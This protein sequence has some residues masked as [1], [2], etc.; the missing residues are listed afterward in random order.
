MYQSSSRSL[1]LKGWNPADW[2]SVAVALDGLGNPSAL[3]THLD[4]FS[5]EVEGSKQNDELRSFRFYMVG[6]VHQ[7]R[8]EYDLALAAYMRASASAGSFEKRAL[9]MLQTGMINTFLGERREAVS[10]LKVALR[11]A[12]QQRSKPDLLSAAHAADFLAGLFSKSNLAIAHRYLKQARRHAAEIGNKHRLDW[13]LFTEGEITLREGDVGAG[14]GLMREALNS[15]ELTGNRSS[16]HHCCARLGAFLFDFDMLAEA[17]AIL[18]RGVELGETF[19]Y[20]RSRTRILKLRAD[21]L[22][23]LGEL[24]PRS[25]QQILD[26]AA[27]LERRARGTWSLMQLRRRIFSESDITEF[28]RTLDPELFESLCFRILTESG[29]TCRRT[30]ES[31]PYIDIVASRDAGMSEQAK[32]AVSCKR[33]NTKKVGTAAIPNSDKIESLGCSGLMIMTSSRISVH[34]EA[35]LEHL[36]SRR[37]WCKVWDRVAL[38]EFLADHDWL[39]A[40]LGFA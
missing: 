18:E 36:K 40:E 23:R 14:L 11:N 33:W 29:F 34:A 31:A 2:A 27:I 37:I 1:K 17:R 9:P 24:D 32:W 19:L 20:N 7:T 21:V 26:R 39:I 12:M 28:L 10:S 13:L 5:T 30:P 22:Y 4:R 16:A 6:R 25:Y 8:G 38:A 3:A 35:D 15:F